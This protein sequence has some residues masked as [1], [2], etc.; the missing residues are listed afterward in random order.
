MCINASYF[1]KKLGE[2]IGLFLKFFEGFCL[3]IFILVLLVGPILLFSAIN[4]VG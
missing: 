3:M 4:P 1:E 2:P